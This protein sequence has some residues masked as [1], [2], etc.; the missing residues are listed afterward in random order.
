MFG[1]SSFP[2]EASEDEEWGPSKRTRKVRHRGQSSYNESNKE[3]KA[4]GVSN[5]HESKSG[6]VCLPPDVVEVCD[7]YFGLDIATLFE[8]NVL[9]LQLE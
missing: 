2:E 7:F 6:R 1:K 3:V 8:G 9:F 5:G 4:R